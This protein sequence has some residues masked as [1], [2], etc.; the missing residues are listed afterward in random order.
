M[1]GTLTPEFAIQYT[2]YATGISFGWPPSLKS[3]RL[4]EIIFRIGWWISYIIC[5]IVVLALLNAGYKHRDNFMHL[6]EFLSVAACLLQ[7]MT[8]MTVGKCHYHR[9]QYLIAEMETFVENA[10]PHERE[11]LTNY[12]NRIV[13][14][15]SIY[16]ISCSVFVGFYIFGPFIT[17]Q[18]LPF[19]AEYPFPFDDHPGYDIVY[20]VETIGA[21]QCSCIV[22]FICQ[23]S[24]LLWY[25]TIQLEF[26]A[27]NI[28]NVNNTQQLKDCIIIHQ[29][30]LWYIDEMTKIVRPMLMTAIIVAMISVPCGGIHIVGKEDTI[31][32]LQFML[33]VIGDGLELLCLSWAAENLTIACQDVTWALY[34]S[35]WIKNSK[36]LNRSVIFVMQRCQI[37]PRLA[38][39]GLVPQLSMSFYASYISTIYSFFTTLRIFLKDI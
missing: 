35:A 2:K 28:R 30:I 29:H 34:S 4:S 33:V 1:S 14:F 25:A 39:G 10:N 3:S 6:T 16:H 32:R 37:P 31:T 5:T 9:F 38:V 17:D 23:V 24:L 19:G 22:A 36:E 7:V 11:I 20:L 27:E 26:L 21:I 18:P 8:K 15:H 12:V 13:P